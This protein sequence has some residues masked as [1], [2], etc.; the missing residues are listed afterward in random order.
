MARGTANNEPVV[1]QAQSKSWDDHFD[2]IQWS[3]SKER[4]TWVLDPRSGKLVRPWEYV[5]S[6]SQDSARNHVLTDRHY[7]GTSSPIDGSDIGSRRKRR[8]HMRAHGVIDANEAHQDGQRN[9]REFK[10]RLSKDRRE[11]LSKTLRQILDMPQA[12]YDRQQKERQDLARR[13]PLRRLPDPDY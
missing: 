13:D 7:E 3:G 2:Q 12:R 10:E 5:S 11:A 9:R 6:D 4:G 1:S 8:E